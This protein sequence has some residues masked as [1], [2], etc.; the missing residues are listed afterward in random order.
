M[1]KMITL[2]NLSRYHGKLLEHYDARVLASA[3]ATGNDPD[4][5]AYLQALFAKGR[6][7]LQ[8]KAHYHIKN[9]VIL[10]EGTDVDMNGAIIEYTGNQYSGV[11]PYCSACGFLNTHWEGNEFKTVLEYNGRGNMRFKNGEFINCAFGFM[12][13][14][15]I[16]F[17][18]ITFGEVRTNHVFQLSACKNVSFL[19]CT[20][21]GI[22]LSNDNGTTEVINLDLS[23]YG[24]F[25]GEWFF[26]SGTATLDEYACRDVT[27]DSCVFRTR[28]NSIYADVFGYHA[29]F[30]QPYKDEVSPDP[31]KLKQIHKCI[32]AVNNYIYGIG[33]KTGDN[34]NTKFTTAFNIRHMMNS[35][36]ANNVCENIQSFAVIDH[37][38]QVTVSGN[39][40]NKNSNNAEAFDLRSTWHRWSTGTIIDPTHETT[41]MGYYTSNK[42]VNIAGNNYSRPIVTFGTNDGSVYT[43]SNWAANNDA[44]PRYLKDGV[45]IHLH[46][47]VKPTGNITLSGEQVVMT[48]PSAVCP[49]DT[50][51]WISRGDSYGSPNDRFSVLV[52][53][54]KNGEL[55]FTP[56]LG[57]VSLTTASD[58]WIDGTYIM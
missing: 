42:N 20:F 4:D 7:L 47:R 14:H 24:Q 54:K 32:R 58:I 11:Q 37:V 40:I 15:D 19:R 25:I 31:D 22:A 6:V 41:N 5:T 21:Y 13:G 49:K 39:V 51:S 35:V 28:N 1:S 12:H 27:V 33:P 55:S 29:N 3:P 16:A 38:R 9:A 8:P 10:P 53:I 52:K 17:E 50:V 34:V 23:A 56:L 43:Q 26:P 30:M 2:D 18:D 57:S 45:I 44:K 36:F 48:L 46:G